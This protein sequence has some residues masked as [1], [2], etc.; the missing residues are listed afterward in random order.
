M[1]MWLESKS[2]TVLVECWSSCATSQ[3]DWNL[4]HLQR[5]WELQWCPS[6][7][8]HL[9]ASCDGDVRTNVDIK[10]IV[11]NCPKKCRA[12]Q[13]NVK[14]FRIFFFSHVTRGRMSSVRT[15]FH[16]LIGIFLD[17]HFSNANHFLLPFPLLKTILR[18]RLIRLCMFS[19]LREELSSDQPR[20]NFS[21]DVQL[22]FKRKL[23]WSFVII[24][25]LSIPSNDLWGGHQKAL[26]SLANDPSWPRSSFRPNQTLRIE[27]QGEVKMLLVTFSPSTFE[28][29]FCPKREDKHSVW[30]FLNFRAKKWSK[31]Q[32]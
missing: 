19:L 11:M 25:N 4:S 23:I 24:L 2:L 26:I 15:M 8:R 13:R 18:A 27:K 7:P 16:L 29:G 12:E 32:E 6:K 1:W 22:F 20:Q 9:K 31:W 30:N 17:E 14:N 10:K 5:Q 21:A 28:F 3:G